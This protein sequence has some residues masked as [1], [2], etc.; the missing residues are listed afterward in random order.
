MPC[1][2]SAPLEDRTQGRRQQWRCISC[3]D[4]ETFVVLAGDTLFCL[5][6]AEFT[7]KSPGAR[8]NLVIPNGKEQTF[9]V[10]SGLPSRHLVILTPGGIDWFFAEMAAG[11][12][13]IVE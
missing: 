7:R 6:G 9:Q 11:Q 2:C 12:L 5:E 13:R 3:Q 1:S 10:I 4:N 8:Q